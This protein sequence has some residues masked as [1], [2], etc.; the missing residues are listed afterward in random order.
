MIIFTD[1]LPVDST[2]YFRATLFNMKNAACCRMWEP[3]EKI[4]AKERR[5]AD[6]DG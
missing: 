1:N 3:R 2:I 5:L 6:A 4:E